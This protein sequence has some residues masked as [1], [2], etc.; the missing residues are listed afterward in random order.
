M[1]SRSYA[2]S[3]ARLLL[4]PGLDGRLR[5]GGGVRPQAG[6]V[7]A[8][9]ATTTSTSTP[10]RGRRPAAEPLP[11]IDALLDGTRGSR[12]FAK[13][14]LASSYHPLRVRAADRWKTSFRSQ[15]GQFEWNLPPLGR[16][17]PT[18]VMNQALTGGPALAG[19]LPVA[20]RP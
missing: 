11:P 2:R 8:N 9:F 6:R 15:L 7:V 18:R 4:D 3:S 1:S 10:S 17:L 16:V 13:L 12:I 14:D 20:P 5:G 19:V